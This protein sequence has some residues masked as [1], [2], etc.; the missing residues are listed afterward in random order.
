MKFTPLIYCLWGILNILLSSCNGLN[1]SQNKS[2]T[3][4]PIIIKGETVTTLDKGNTI[5]FQDNKNNYWFAGGGKG[6][7]KYD[8]KSLVLF[9]TKDGLCS[10]S[11]LGI[12]EDKLG[13]IYFDT[14]EGVSKFDGQ[15]FVTLKVI[16]NNSSKNKWKL[17][18]D[19]LW[20][21]MGW[22]TDGPYRYDGNFLYQ[23]TF[24][25]PAQADTFYAKYPNATFTPY[26][27]YSLYKDSKGAIWFGTASLGLCRYDG[28]SISW[29]YE[30][31]MTT[32]PDG[33]ALGIRSIFEDQAGYFWFTNTRY[34]YDILLDN[35]AKNG[36]N[37]I[38]YKKK[39]GIGYSNKNNEIEFPYFMSITEDKQGNLWM[40]SNRNGVWYSDRKKLIH[41][42]IEN[43]QSNLIPFSI[44]KDNQGAIWLG[45]YNA[46]IYRF[47]GN[48]FEKFNL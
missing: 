10:H 11:I 12:Q 7:Y 27:I 46:G 2:S 23:L 24:P 21:R 39:K 8:G 15:Q 35:L 44:Y 17:E 42:S 29:L 18:P 33:G 31:Q 20:F 45:T 47:N 5:I 9:T 25:K 40:A 22:N 6:A 41:Y 36:A 3:P 30:E 13:N 37:Y 26:G 1:T 16:S 28:E 48:S 38:K 32:T 14:Q 43:N 4:N 19:D 34:Q